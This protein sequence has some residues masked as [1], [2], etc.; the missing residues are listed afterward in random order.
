MKRFTAAEDDYIKA[1][2]LEQTLTQIGDVFNRPF[3]SI[4]GRIIRLGL[5]V[6]AEIIQQRRIDGLKLGWGNTET[7]F[8]KGHVTWNKGMKGLHI[9][10]GETQ[11]KKGNQPYNTKYNGAVSIR[12]DKSGP[13][14]KYMRL[15]KCKWVLLQRHIWEQ[16]KGPIPEGYIVKFAD[17]N[18]MNCDIANLYLSTR[19]QNMDSNNIRRY[20]A[21]L[22]K[23][24]KLLS[25]LNKQ[26]KKVRV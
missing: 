21:E 23:S 9:G 8:K 16:S 26:L 22:K 12:K 19:A 24:I 14:Y 20:P 15:D 1:H 25:K 2:Y 5:V 4:H 6:P 10:G 13:A 11:F 3:G 18:S 17:G 7:R